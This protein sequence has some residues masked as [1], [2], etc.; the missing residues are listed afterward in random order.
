[1]DWRQRA[2]CQY[3][4]PDDFFPHPKQ[5]SEIKRAKRICGSCP[6]M[7]QCRTWALATDQEYGIWGGYSEQQL[8]EQ[9]QPDS[10]RINK[11]PLADRKEITRRRARIARQLNDEG[12]TVREIAETLNVTATTV[13]NYLGMII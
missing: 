13:R 2:A 10:S 8:R 12:K 6:V 1:M 5:T 9:I 4:N 7:E 11:L 3:Y